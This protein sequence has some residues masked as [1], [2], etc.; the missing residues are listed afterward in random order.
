[1]LMHI[2]NSL[3]DWMLQMLVNRSSTHESIM[4][5]T[6]SHILN[7]YFEIKKSQDL[8]HPLLNT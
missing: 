6:Q 3:F 2:K 7:S 4:T 5:P 1:M 8:D